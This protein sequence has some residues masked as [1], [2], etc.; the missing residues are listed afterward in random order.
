MNKDV[1]G[2]LE[3]K[4][5]DAQL[6]IHDRLSPHGLK[7]LSLLFLATHEEFSASKSFQLPLSIEPYQILLFAKV[8]QNQTPHPTEINAL[9]TEGSQ[10]CEI[11]HVLP[12]CG[13][14]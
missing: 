13:V 10:N 5:T 2:D 3:K 12:K 7:E 11:F 14:A 6:P 9:M 1:F 8:S 4:K